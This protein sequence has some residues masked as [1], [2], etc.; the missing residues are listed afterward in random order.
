[1]RCFD[2]GLKFRECV[3]DASDLHKVQNF[4]VGCISCDVIHVVI[5]T[6]NGSFV[7]PQTLHRQVSYPSA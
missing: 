3:H 6:F 2:F 1:M 4:L 5:T 7:F